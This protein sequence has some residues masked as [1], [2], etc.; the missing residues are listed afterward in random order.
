MYLDQVIG[1]F[2]GKHIS[3]FWPFRGEPDLW[4]WM[5]NL[6]A[7][8]AT[9]LLPVVVAK[10]E[11]LIFRSWTVGQ[12][13]ER[14]VWNIPVPAGGPQTVPDIVKA[15][16]FAFDSECFRLGYGGGFFDRTV[17]GLDHKPWTIGVGFGIQQI[18][19]VYP[20]PPKFP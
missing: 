6:S 19:T 4:R 13:L 7:S 1:D 20:L 10:C 9:S 16:L 14:E 11:P 5:D 3:V 12:P 18:P 2:A 8:N 17:A 15:P